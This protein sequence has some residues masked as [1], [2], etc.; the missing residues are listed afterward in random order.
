MTDAAGWNWRFR[1]VY[2]ALK[3]AFAVIATGASVLGFWICMQ[4]LGPSI[5]A[6]VYPVIKDVTLEPLPAELGNGSI[7]FHVKFTKQ[8]DCEH[9]GRDWF[10]VLPDGSLQSI[11]AQY[12]DWND[13]PISRP[14]GRHRGEKTVLV[15]PVD[16]I[17]VFGTQRHQCYMP[18]GVSRTGI[19]PFPLSDWDSRAR[20]KPFPPEFHQ[21][22][23]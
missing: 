3:R 8:R 21:L 4:I 2:L 22:F 20:G 1:G 23:Q 12:P 16:A 7:A 11:Q 15:P 10:A 17:G 13:P 19:G 14:P 9:R 5:E 18:W 6:Q